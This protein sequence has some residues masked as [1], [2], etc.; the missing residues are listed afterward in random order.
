MNTQYSFIRYDNG[1]D[2]MR[3]NWSIDLS[4]PFKDDIDPRLVRFL[5]DLIYHK[6]YKITSSVPIY[7]KYHIKKEDWDHIVRYVKK[8]Q[9]SIFSKKYPF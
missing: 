7:M 8:Y 9:L 6:I 3:D 5:R 1:Y 4:I 2:I